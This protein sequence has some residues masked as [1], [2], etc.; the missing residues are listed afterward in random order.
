[1]YVVC[2]NTEIV[3]CAFLSWTVLG[4][5]VNRYQISAIAL[6]IGSVIFAALHPT[7]WKF[8][9]NGGNSN[10]TPQQF[11]TGIVL[12]VSSR[13]LSACNSIV[14]Q[15]MLGANKKSPW[16]V[17]ELCI[18]Q[19]LAPSIVLPFTLLISHE[20]RWWSNLGT[21]YPN[22]G[23]TALVFILVALSLTKLVDRTCKM[24]IIAAKSTIYFEGI[25]AVMKSVAGIGAYLFW[26]NTEPAKWNHFFALAVI[27]LSLGLT[28]HGENVEKKAEEAR[29]KED[30]GFDYE[31]MEK[32]TEAPGNDPVGTSH[33]R[34]FANDSTEGSAR[35][36]VKST[37]GE[38]KHSSLY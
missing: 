10:S 25:D 6:V 34:M 12:T 33:D 31:L 22:P 18:A 19:A 3:F 13:F 14:A 8:D 35:Q 1:M 4:Q 36:R 7:T 16:G 29:K 37:V 5:H 17:H 11:I 24:S 32:A 2:A 26:P 30:E 27:M 9:A 23:T 15:K 28:I 38:L 21:N 20:N